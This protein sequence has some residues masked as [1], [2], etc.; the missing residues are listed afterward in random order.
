MK[1]PQNPKNSIALATLRCGSVHVRVRVCIRVGRRADTFVGV[2]VHVG[3][4][5]AR[6]RNGRQQATCD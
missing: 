5:R 4:A 1:F 3:D 2:H 6:G